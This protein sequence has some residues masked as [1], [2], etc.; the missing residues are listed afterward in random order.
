MKKPPK[1]LTLEEPGT[2]HRQAQAMRVGDVPEDAPSTETPG[3]AVRRYTIVDM[4][5]YLA[6][7]GLICPR[8]YAG[9]LHWK[10]DYLLGVTQPRVTAKYGGGVGGGVEEWT[11]KRLAA[12]KRWYTAANYIG[13]RNPYN[14]REYLACFGIVLEDESTNGRIV[15][16]RSALRALADWYAVP[17]DAEKV[18]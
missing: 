7:R 17:F 10:E 11:Q 1:R 8:Q 4:L 5:G 6:R 2:P 18:A 13:M 12:R 16:V 3:T 14:R 9:G 15:L